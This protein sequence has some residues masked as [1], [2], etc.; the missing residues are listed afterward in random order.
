MCIGI[1]GIKNET[2]S[3]V[4]NYN[5]SNY[6]TVCSVNNMEKLELLY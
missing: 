1:N 2:L 6:T 3:D 4:L 5:S